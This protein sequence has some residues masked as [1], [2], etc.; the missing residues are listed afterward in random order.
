MKNF[1][2]LFI[3]GFI[4][5]NILFSCDQEKLSKHLVNLRKLNHKIQQNDWIVKQQYSTDLEEYFC[6]TKEKDNAYYM[7][8]FSYFPKVNKYKH[9]N[10]IKAFVEEDLYHELSLINNDT[11]YHFTAHKNNNVLKD[12]S[13]LKL[14]ELNFISGWYYYLYIH[15]NYSWEQ[16]EY[17]E[18]NRDSLIKIK[19]GNLP[20][21]PKN[22]Q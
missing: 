3:A 21:L 6:I 19:G 22:H 18:S 8:T 14:E 4:L 10:Y 17:F 12:N 5:S 16:K 9:E 7:L 2:K 1:I 15:G 11:L 20:P 13:S